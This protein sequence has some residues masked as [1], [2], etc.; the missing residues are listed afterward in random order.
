MGIPIDDDTATSI[1]RKGLNPDRY[2]DIVTTIQSLRTDPLQNYKEL[3]EIL[4][5]R[6]ETIK[7]AQRHHGIEKKPAT[8]SYV[9]TT[10]MK[11]CPLH[12]TNSHDG[13]ECRAMKA[14]QARQY[15][16][17]VGGKPQTTRLPPKWCKFCARKVTNHTEPTC[18]K[19]PANKNQR[20]GTGTAARL[21]VTEEVPTPDTTHYSLQLSNTQA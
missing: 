4:K 18:F 5:T 2:L 13:K 6:E 8:S 9:A 10:S 16:Q 11:Y 12:K 14:N 1:F 21:A 17:P 3:F 19:N 15:C 7:G 20:P